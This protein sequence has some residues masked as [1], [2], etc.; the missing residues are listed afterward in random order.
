[1][2]LMRRL[3]AALRGEDPTLTQIRLLSEAFQA[4]LDAVVESQKSQNAVISQWFEMFKSNTDTQ[5]G[6]VNDDRREWLQEIRE[7]R[8]EGSFPAGLSDV[9]Q[10]DWL[11][12][13]LSGE[14][15]E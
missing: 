2:G 9:E 5:K 1:M 11:E 7:E 10:L 15:G 13:Q 3:A 6:W 14:S 12:K 8:G 4:S